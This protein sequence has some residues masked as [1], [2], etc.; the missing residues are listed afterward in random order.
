MFNN[1]IFCN[2]WNWSRCDVNRHC[3]SA[4][5][6][7]ERTSTMQ[8]CQD[9]DFCHNYYG[10]SINR[11]IPTSWLS[12]WNTSTEHP[13]HSAKH[14]KI[15]NRASMRCH[16]TNITMLD[17]H[18]KGIFQ[19]PY[20]RRICAGLLSDRCNASWSYIHFGSTSAKV[21]DAK[22]V[23]PLQLKRIQKI[24]FNISSLNINVFMV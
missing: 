7:W 8:K 16:N 11:A 24:A 21:S 14:N 2:N 22:I 19:R 10:N 6:E 1:V 23:R 12:R 3:W 4:T 9:D 5:C 17:L 18:S 15:N 13:R 20:I